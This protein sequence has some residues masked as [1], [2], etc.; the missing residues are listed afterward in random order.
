MNTGGDLEETGIPATWTTLTTTT[1]TTTTTTTTPRG[2][3][4]QPQ[5]H[6]QV[7]IREKVFTRVF[8]LL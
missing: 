4:Q 8:F 1:A 5:Q 3:Q 6:R 7:R 2:Q